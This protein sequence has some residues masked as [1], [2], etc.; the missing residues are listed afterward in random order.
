MENSLKD[1]IE[2]NQIMV[3]VVPMETYEDGLK[4]I[5]LANSQLKGLLCYI[6]LNK[7]Y[8]TLLRNFEKSG[9][10][11]KGLFFIDS[12]SGRV[13]KDENVVFVS[14]PKALTELSI[15]ITEN[16][17]REFG[18]FVLDS[19]STL[20]IYEDTAAAVKFTHFLISKARMKNKKFIFTFLQ[21]DS[22]KEMMKD[23]NMFVD[24]VIIAS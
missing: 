4:N 17:D 5:V 23:I 8:S 2:Q 22:K 21:E 6:S 11:T 13:G 24:K 18:T 12:V 9:L 20:M 19:L 16:M 10:S 3:Y 14:S 15:T 1:D 7:P